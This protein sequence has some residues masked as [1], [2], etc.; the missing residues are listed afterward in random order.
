MTAKI[1]VYGTLMRE[2]ID[3]IDQM[4]QQT[5]MRFIGNG[6]I[7][8]ELFDLGEF[9]GAIEKKGNYVYGE[10]FEI[11]DSDEVFCLLDKYEEYDPKNPAGSLFVR[12]TTKVLMTDRRTFRASAYFYNGRTEGLRKIASGKWK[13][14]TKKELPKAM[15]YEFST[16]LDQ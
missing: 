6:T 8:A 13:K 10:V 4:S 5:L 3:K 11:K 1:F 9:P 14:P 15:A 16:N 7:E 2:N 12:K